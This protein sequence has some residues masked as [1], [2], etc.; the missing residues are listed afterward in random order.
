[1]RISDLLKRSAPLALGVG[2]VV[3]ASCETSPTPA[4][5]LVLRPDSASL[6]A[7]SVLALEPVFVGGAAEPLAFLSS[8]P[9]VATVDSLGVVRARW[10]GSATIRAESTRRPALAASAR[11]TVTGPALRLAPDSLDVATGFGWARLAVQTT[12]VA[13]GRV[14]FQSA[15][16]RIARV[17]SSGLACPVSP[18]RTFIRASAESNPAL[19]DSA[20]VR[21]VLLPPP[22]IPPGLIDVRD[23]AG[24][25]IGSSPASGI[26]QV[27]AFWWRWMCDTPDTITAQLSI[28]GTLVATSGPRRWLGP[29]SVFFRVDTRALDAAGRRRYPDGSHALKVSFQAANGPIVMVMGTSIVIANGAGA[30]ARPGAASAPEPSRSRVGRTAPRSASD[31]PS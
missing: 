25:H 17:D 2:L 22:P 10:P 5:R 1:M 3:A 20:L 19:L 14:T 18:G 6:P 13:P 9:S 7:H 16:A 23:S 31:P 28:D 24:A 12:G 27:V 26:I 8:D 30:T 4:W 11:L 21:V 15:D 29:D